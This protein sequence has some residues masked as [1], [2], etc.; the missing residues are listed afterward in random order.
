[1]SNF[2][3]LFYN[4]ITIDRLGDWAEISG[5]FDSIL[6]YSLLG[7]FFLM[8]TETGQC[9]VLFTMPPELVDLDFHGV[10]SFKNGCL[11]HEII[12]EDVL[13]EDKIVQLKDKLG[14][15]DIDEIYIPEP[16]PFLGGN[17]SLESYGKGNVWVFMELIGSLQLKND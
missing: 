1:M 8:D 9:A 14:P 15:L 16:Y 2:C 11:S 6:G 3:V 12:R 13:Q 5:S 4:P 17:L 7:D 10:E